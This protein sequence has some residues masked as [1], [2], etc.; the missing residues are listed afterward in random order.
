MRAF[1]VLMMV[2]GHTVHTFLDTDLRI[3]DSIFYLVWY[4]LRGFTAPIFM[5][6]AGVVFTYLLYLNTKA[7]NK[8]RLIKGLKRFLLLVF[9]GYLLRYP[10][11]TVIDFSNVSEKQW[12]I[13]FGV[14]ALHL[15]GF[16]LLFII[17][18]SVIANKIKISPYITLLTGTLFFVL[19]YPITSTINWSE[20]LPAPIAAY[21][22]KETGSL[23]PLFPWAGYVLG[24]SLL[25]VFLAHN[26]G[27]FK[28][29]R[30]G[31]GLILI[32]LSFMFV[33]FISSQIVYWFK[34]SYDTD[35][36]GV[37]IFFLRVGF[38]IALNG[39]VALIVIRVENIP[40]LIKLVGRHTLLIYI[41]HLVILYGN[42]WVPG[43]YNSI[44]Q[45]FSILLTLLAVLLMYS[46]MIGM[47]VAL[48]RFNKYRREKFAV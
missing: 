43:L 38:V 18:L 9:L 46:L 15:I 19:L 28:K 42:A 6:T 14:D 17:I 34:G 24:G 29:K 37:A 10:T 32:G 33:Y 35:I 36:S 41:V 16:G 8:A 20:F 5:F 1:A 40:H 13:F 4:T 23:F 47:V 12:Q 30:F 22:Y 27:I 44:G 31:S 45:Q 2:Q 11:H 21:M 25:G 7:P 48:E 3:T 26:H 39:A